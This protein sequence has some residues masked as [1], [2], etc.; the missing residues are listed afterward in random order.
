MD[1]STPDD[2][3]V[4]DHTWSTYHD[5]LHGPEPIP[6]W[7]ITSSAAIDD[8]L[9][10]LKS[11]KEADVALV[12]RTLGDRSALHA[13]KRYRDAHHRMFH[14]DAGYLEG[15][16]LKKTRETRA[17]ATRTSFGREIIAAQWAIA[18]FSMLS[19][20][21]SLGAPVPY[22]V[23]LYDDEI[24]MEFIGDADGVA[25]PRLAQLR[26]DREEAAA[27]YGQLHAALVVLADAGYTHGDLSAYNVLVHEGRV[28]LIDLPQVVDLTGNP[29]GPSYLERDCTN[30]CQWFESRGLPL[31]ARAMTDELLHIAGMR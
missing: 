10:V 28:V 14:R 27:L 1:T 17:V 25:A 15:R 18:E 9:G 22:P 16:R 20:L 31:D 19:R 23:Q 24:M 26:P 2:D 30:I 6:D 12:R 29:Q 13:V 3:A 4:V 11:G 7:V 21:W 5:A 8:D